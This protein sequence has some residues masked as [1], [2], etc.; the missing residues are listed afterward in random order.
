MEIYVI[1][2]DSIDELR[3]HPKFK[4]DMFELRIDKKTN[5]EFGVNSFP[6]AL[7]YKLY[8]E[9]LESQ[10]KEEYNPYDNNFDEG[11]DSFQTY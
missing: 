4:T 6:V 3:K 1:A 9:I 5:S 7:P 8:K 2:I 10:P 11:F